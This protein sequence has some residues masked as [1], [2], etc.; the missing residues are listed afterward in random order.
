[1]VEAIDTT[2]EAADTMVENVEGTAR[3]RAHQVEGVLQDSRKRVEPH[4]S[5]LITAIGH[6][7]QD[8]L[9]AEVPAQEGQQVTG[10]ASAQC[11]ASI[12]STSGACSPSPGARGVSPPGRADQLAD[13]VHADFGDQG[14]QDPPRSAH[15]AGRRRPGHTAAD[16]HPGPVGGAPADQLGDQA[17][18]A[19]TGLAPPPR[20]TAG[21][22]I[23]GRQGS[24]SPA[25]A[26][27]RRDIHHARPEGGTAAVGASE[28]R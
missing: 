28:Q 25:A 20:T 18:L 12:T 24:G 21:S 14:P 1:V 8:P 23:G 5:G 7:Q 27:S 19:D 22:V 2:A 3:D 26:P 16:Q 9:P 15:R 13:L 17:C 11:R 4:T 6:H 10:G